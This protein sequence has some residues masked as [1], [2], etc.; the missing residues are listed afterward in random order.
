MSSESHI[1]I[2]VGGF[3]VI[4]SV[5]LILFV[6]GV[7]QGFNYY[8]CKNYGSITE[9]TTKYSI[10]NGC[11]VKISSGWILQEKMSKRVYINSITE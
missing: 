8:T 6:L 1:N 11:F 5:L 3:G 4:V 10:V 2:S 7:A 9:R